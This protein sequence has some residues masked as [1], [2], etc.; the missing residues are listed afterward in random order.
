MKKLIVVCI[1]C[2]S[3]LMPVKASTVLS[4]GINIGL[5]IWGYN[6]NTRFGNVAGTVFALRGTVDLFTIRW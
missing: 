2:L 4:T 6:Q 3:C 5:A 1:I